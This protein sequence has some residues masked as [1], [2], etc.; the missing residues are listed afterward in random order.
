MFFLQAQETPRVV[1]P[2]SAARAMA[3]VTGLARLIPGFRHIAA[4]WI[5]AGVAWF[6]AFA[7][8]LNFG[9]L[10]PVAWPGLAARVS[11]IVLCAAALLIAWAS[12]RRAGMAERLERR[13]AE[14]R[15]AGRHLTG[16]GVEKQLHA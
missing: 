15:R 5:L 4:G 13:R 9:V 6:T 11:R 2:D 14:R 3:L 8:V 10:A 16:S 7:A 12:H 1:F